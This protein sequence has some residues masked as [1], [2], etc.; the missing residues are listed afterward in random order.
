MLECILDLG[1]GFCIFSQNPE[2]A[3]VHLARF[4][5]TEGFKKLF[6]D[7]STEIG[8]FLNNLTS[9]LSAGRKKG[10]NVIHKPNEGNDI[11][12]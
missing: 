11:E 12:R 4:N 3:A 10:Q 6:T 2:N 9:V 8:E 1:N 5:V 7:G